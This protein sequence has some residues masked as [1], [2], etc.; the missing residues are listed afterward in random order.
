MVAAENHRIVYTVVEVWRGIAGDVHTF[1]NEVEALEC[2]Q[3]LQE[4]HNPLEDDVE[5]FESRVR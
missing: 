2:Y 3:R 1:S 4:E 5:M